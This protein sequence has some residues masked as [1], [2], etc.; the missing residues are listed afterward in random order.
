[1]QPPGA[2]RGA[3]SAVDRTDEFDVELADR[4]GAGVNTRSCHGSRSELRAPHRDH[5]IRKRPGD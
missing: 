5:G 2:H 3:I 1:M 4:L